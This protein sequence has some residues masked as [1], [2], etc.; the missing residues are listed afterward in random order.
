[1]GHG[2][3]NNSCET[4]RISATLTS[5]PASWHA[6]DSG[7]RDV[8]GTVGYEPVPV[9]E[10]SRLPVLAL[11]GVRVTVTPPAESAAVFQ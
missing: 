2:A 6:P 7:G 11:W 9:L 8:D 3:W 5:A 4:D 10:R 1:M